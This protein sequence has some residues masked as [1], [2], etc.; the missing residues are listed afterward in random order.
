MGGEK[1]GLDYSSQPDREPSCTILTEERLV[2][3]A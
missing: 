1:D 2:T 3:M